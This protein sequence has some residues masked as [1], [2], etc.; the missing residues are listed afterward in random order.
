MCPTRRIFF[1][2]AKHLTERM[3][4][5]LDDGDCATDW[6]LVRQMFTT[7]QGERK[8]NSVVIF[9][10]L[11]QDTKPYQDLIPVDQ[12]KKMMETT[13]TVEK[14]LLD[15]VS[16]SN[17]FRSEVTRIKQGYNELL[18]RVK[19][20]YRAKKRRARR[21]QLEGSTDA[22][23]ETEDT[24]PTKNQKRKQ[25]RKKAARLSAEKKKRARDDEEY[26]DMPELGSDRS[27]EEHNE[28]MTNRTDAQPCKVSAEL[29]APK[30]K[31]TKRENC[32]VV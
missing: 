5:L 15:N 19:R 24:T 7:H 1:A 20:L 13:I 26:A 4:Q 16:T 32:V 21:A 3:A 11:L 22:D 27:D 2:F 30:A 14:C 12:L 6:V 29:R 17:F 31:K 28:M 25:R 18:E 9:Q 10:R 8:L 23:E